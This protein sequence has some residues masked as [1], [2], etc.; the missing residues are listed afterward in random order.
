MKILASGM[1]KK[2]LGNALMVGEAYAEG[3][4]CMW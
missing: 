2:C 3:R 1:D 4:A